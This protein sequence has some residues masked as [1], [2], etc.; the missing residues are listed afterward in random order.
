MKQKLKNLLV[1]GGIMAVFDTF[2]LPADRN[3]AFFNVLSYIISMIF[4]FLSVFLFFNYPVHFITDIQKKYPK[5]TTYLIHIGWGPY[6]ILIIS[7]IFSITEEYRRETLSP[8][9]Y[10]LLS[11]RILETY[12]FII[13][14]ML[15]LATY[16][17]LKQTKGK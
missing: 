12:Y 3:I 10:A 11:A 9:F 5:I 13:V 1:L 17:I 16:K 14:L 2:F 4:F 7:V 15:F 8:E 6:V